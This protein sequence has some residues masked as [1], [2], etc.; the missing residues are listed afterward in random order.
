MHFFLW[1]PRPQ[2]LLSLTGIAEAR[3]RILEL[4]FKP[5]SQIVRNGIANL[6]SSLM[7]MFKRIK[8]EILLLSVINLVFLLSVHLVGE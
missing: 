2:V 5:F 4:L 6:T 8:S 3:I 7:Q 1:A